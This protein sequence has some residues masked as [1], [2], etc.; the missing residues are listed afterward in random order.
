MGKT[1]A[2]GEV[3]AQCSKALTSDDRVA[4]GD[5]L[6]CR[7]CYATLRQE[8]ASAVSEM[9]T[10]V[11]WAGAVT[12]AV[13]GG[14]IGALV[15]WG[16]TVLTHIALGLVAIAIGFLVGH[17]TVRLSGGKR[18]AGLQALSVGVA[19]VSFLIAV[20]LVNMSLINE[21]FAKEGQA[22]RIGFPASGQVFF[23]VVAA[24]FG[25]MDLVF[26]A[27]VVYEAWKIPRP[28]ALPADAT[29]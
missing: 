1:T 4:S 26:L 27:I 3:C 23:N 22:V 16:F 29:A 15:W 12:G 20:Y 2:G 13:L 24:D 7:S 21:M 25:I 9:S 10:N 17:G 14:A 5:R 28:I 18:T 6:F 11:N 8:L 19:L